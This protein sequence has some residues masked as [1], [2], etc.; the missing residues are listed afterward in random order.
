MF[1]DINPYKMKILL[2]VLTL[3]TFVSCS[4]DNNFSKI[5]KGMKSAEVIALVGQ[6]NTKQP[7]MMVEW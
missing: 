5:H 1:A 7:M 6:P 4:S 3:A 2:F